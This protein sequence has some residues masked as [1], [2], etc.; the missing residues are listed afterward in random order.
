LIEQS[1]VG[2]RFFQRLPHRLG[3]DRLDQPQNDHLV[4]QQLQCPAARA[5]WRLSASQF[6]E[7][8]LNVSFDLVRPH[9]PG[10][11]IERC[12]NALGHKPLTNAGD[13]PRARTQSYD[14]VLVASIVAAHGIG[15]E[16]NAGV[17]QLATCSFPG[18][19]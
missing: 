13:S 9:R 11:G 18:R 2:C 19:D 15:Q 14:D 7:L 12:F 4:S 5:T 3:A 8:L 16:Q 1:R 17:S 10:F 6:D